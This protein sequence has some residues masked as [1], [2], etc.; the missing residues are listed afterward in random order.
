M[1]YNTIKWKKHNIKKLSDGRPYQDIHSEVCILTESWN[2]VTAV[3][4]IAYM[5]E[6]GR[7]L[8]LINE[9]YPHH[10][11]VLSSDD[12]GTTWSEPEYIH[13]DF[14]GNPDIGFCVGLTY[15]GNGKAAVMRCEQNEIWF[16]NDFGSTW[17]NPVKEPPVFGNKL[18][19]SAW[20]PFF[21]DRCNIKGRTKRLVLA[22]HVAYGNG[23]HDTGYYC[24]GFIRF[25]TDEG[26]TWG[27]DTEVPQWRNVNEIALA[28]AIN[29]DMIA[30][31]RLD[32]QKEY[33]GCIDHYE[34]LGIS[35][36]TDDGYTWSDIRILYDFGR[37]HPSMV[38]MQ[39][40]SIIMTYVVRV[41]YPDTNDGFKQ[42]GIEAVASFD[43][44]RSWD[45]DNRYILARWQSNRKGD[46]YWWGSC[47]STSS[48]LLPDGN[49]LTAFGTGYRSQPNEN[50]L[51]SPRDIGLIKWKV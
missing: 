21:V 10:G 30:A 19:Y 42:F 27:M 31:C 14:H 35:I 26:W 50:G 12:L 37:H 46:N 49:I 41:G 44:G 47:Q 24:Q 1:D 9:G 20:D 36:S 13:K 5:P 32:R 51:P 2:C 25:S 28:R 39:D 23:Y 17:G 22:G 3:P 16:S 38:V 18:R 48:V 33:I 8:A 45:M 15:M 34:G 40:G 43:N 11:M 7:I 29:G 6:I 4:F